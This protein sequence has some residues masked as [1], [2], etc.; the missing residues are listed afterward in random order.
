M[1]N[2]DIIRKAVELADGWSFNMTGDI[3]V[4]NLGGYWWRNGNLEQPLLNALAAQ[5][6]EQAQSNPYITF[7]ISVIDSAC[8]VEMFIYNPNGDEEAQPLRF[9]AHEVDESMAFFKVIVDS[10]VLKPKDGG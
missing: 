1:D 5:L 7:N 2:R 9:V 4:R 6:R 3:N 8:Y 10:Q